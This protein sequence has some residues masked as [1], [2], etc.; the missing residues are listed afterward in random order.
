MGQCDGSADL[1]LGQAA[2]VQHRQQ[3][4]RWRRAGPP[5]RERRART[6]AP[7]AGR[8]WSRASGP[9]SRPRP[10]R[11]YKRRGTPR[12]GTA[13]LERLPRAPRIRGRPHP[14]AAAPTCCEADGRSET[15]TLSQVGRRRS[16]GRTAACTAERAAR[17]ARAQTKRGQRQ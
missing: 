13:P 17:T 6:S 11:R 3:G 8:A 2:V 5:G 9:G 1:H 4:G 10:L 7:P 12:P 16:G 15:R 14:P